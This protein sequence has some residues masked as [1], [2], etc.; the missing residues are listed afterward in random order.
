LITE[1]YTDILW[2]H[3]KSGCRL[4]TIS[5]LTVVTKARSRLH[6]IFCVFL[7]DKGR[8]ISVNSANVQNVYART[9]LTDS[10]SDSNSCK[11]QS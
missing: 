11:E 3:E 4:E 9:A 6:G 5:F 7:R 1:S 2:D 10:S 8:K